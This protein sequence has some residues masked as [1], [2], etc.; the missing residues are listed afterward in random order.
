MSSKKFRRARNLPPEREPATGNSGPGTSGD[1]DPRSPKRIAALLAG[2]LLSRAFRLV[3]AFILAIAGVLLIIAWQLAPERALDAAKFRH[4][5]AHAEGRIVESWLA[6]EWNPAD[7]GELLRWHAF[8]TGTPCAIVEYAGDWGTPERRAFCGNHFRL[9][10]DSVLHDFTQMAPGVPFSWLRDQ[11]GFMVPEIRMSRASLQW[12]SMH[13]PYATF[14]LEQ[15]PPVTALEALKSQL[16]HPVDAAVASW[17]APLPDIALSLDRDR[18]AA[19]MP[20]AWVDGRRTFSVGNWFFCVLLAIPGIV[21]WI[22][23][24]AL[25]LPNV[26]AFAR[27]VLS[28]LP[29]LTLPWWSEQFPDVLRTVSKDLAGIVADVLGDVD[30]TGRMVGS[31]PEEAL[32]VDGERLTFP[33]AG[34]AYASSF[35]RVRFELPNP[36]PASGDAA[37]AALTITTTAQVRAL[38]QAEQARLYA[39]LA[40]DKARDLRGAGM[41]FVL[42]AKAALLDA[43]TDGA[44]R[45][46]ARRF[47]SNWVTQP[48]EEPRRGD[49]SYT[50]RVRLFSELAEVPIPEIWIMAKS[51]VERAR[52]SRD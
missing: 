4:F 19:A 14:M 32:L 21:L 52:A 41:I 6:V 40:E 36:P 27:R 23:G 26:P 18:P 39:Q 48:I 29:L 34:R 24:M 30:R 46:A 7:M 13:P 9:R 1:G 25:L 51:V 22:R 3:A 31:A 37:L 33:L 47:L 2:T 10:E 45:A 16:D 8:A 44:T 28:I 12:L 38:G 17:S 20:A 15:P 42:A 43:Q 5:T 50:E 49:A 11:R 35:G